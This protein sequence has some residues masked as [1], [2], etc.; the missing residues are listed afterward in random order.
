MLFVAPTRPL[1]RT[2]V[3]SASKQLPDQTSIPIP[4]RKDPVLQANEHFVRKA[5]V[6]RASDL[7]YES[8][9]IGQT[10]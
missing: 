2:Q 10:L 3:S 7:V 4:F 5:A 6:S 1:N 8:Q 9:N